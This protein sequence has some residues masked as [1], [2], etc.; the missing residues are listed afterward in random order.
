MEVEILV[1]NAR[2]PEAFTTEKKQ[3]FDVKCALVWVPRHCETHG[4]LQ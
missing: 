3:T 4:G 1:K 2:C